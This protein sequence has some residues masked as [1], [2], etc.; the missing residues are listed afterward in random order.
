MDNF[1]DN[2][3]AVA[4][5]AGAASR[6]KRVTATAVQGKGAREA[7]F[8]RPATLTAGEHA[9]TSPAGN[10]SRFS[11]ENSAKG[12]QSSDDGAPILLSLVGL[13]GVW[14]LVLPQ[15]LAALGLSPRVPELEGCFGGASI[16]GVV[17]PRRSQA[18]RE[19]S[20]ICIFQ[21]AGTCGPH[22]SVDLVSGSTLDAKRYN[23]R[24]NLRMINQS[25]LRGVSPRAVTSSDIVT[26]LSGVETRILRSSCATASAL[27]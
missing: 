3:C 8:A 6:L 11:T 24:S 5:P 15:N 20:A 21:A 27:R 14:P 4:A 23:G 7:N 26:P 22:R 13:A 9:M 19:T 25:N 17:V 10:S 12:L 16:D 1:W 18:A 2:S